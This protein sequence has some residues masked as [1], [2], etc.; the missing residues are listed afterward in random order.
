MRNRVQGLVEYTRPICIKDTVN[1]KVQLFITMYEKEVDSYTY[2]CNTAEFNV[3]NIIMK[4][5][6]E[7]KDSPNSFVL[8]KHHE[9]KLTEFISCTT[10]RGRQDM[11]SS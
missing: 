2:T 6:L 9:R 3:H 5:S 11:R 7:T 8:N 1:S 4:V 10:N